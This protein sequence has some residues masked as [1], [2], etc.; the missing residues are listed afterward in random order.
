[1][2]KWA[3][4]A[5]VPLYLFACLL[6]GGSAQGIWANMLV[7]LVGV[8]VIAW[9]A[10]APAGN[11][12]VRSQHRLLLVAGAGLA[13]AAIQLV[14]LP[15]TVWPQLG[16]RA[17]IA[18]GFEVLGMHIPAL[19]ISL[20][21]YDSVAALF[22]FVPPLAILCAM[23]RLRAYRA[24]WL[25]FALIAGAIAGV[26]LGMLQVSGGPD[27]PWYLYQR[28]N[29]GLATGF[30]ANANHMATLLVVSLPFL[31]AL[32]ASA[33]GAKVQRYSAA[34]ALVGATALV[35]IVG[36]ALNG[37][38]AGY[39]LVVPVLLGSG[40][41]LIPASTTV[42]RVAGIGAGL[43]LIAALFALWTTPIG[44][45][46]L[47]EDASSSVQSRQEILQTSVGPLRDF[48]PFGSGLGTYR[49]V[50]QLYEDHVRID[51]TFVRHA[52]NDY[53][54]LAVET[55]IPGLI[56]LIAF[57]AWWAAAAGTA[58]RSAGA[59]LGRAA[60]IASAAILAHSLVDYPLRTAA[61]AATFAMCLG[62]LV[63][64]RVERDADKSDLWATRHIVL[65]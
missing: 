21:P 55:G 5:V 63:E 54:E 39:A 19:S 18:S 61:I 23:M 65:E 51:P 59:P 41:I 32:L 43:L 2:A 10:M 13:V 47:G 28:T 48:M 1:M 16:G 22:A 52:H 53:L 40:L 29:R 64:R 6:L 24:S 45:R 11:P 25:A 4:E 27:S 33:Q 60:A 42:R 35:V 46:S 8:A 7:Q 44:S 31:A 62:L 12:L 3:R 36:I 57:L 14:P 34:V 38:L 30:F 26:L 9:A 56:V 20:A 49:A 58:W 15:A 37:S 17:R 50:Y